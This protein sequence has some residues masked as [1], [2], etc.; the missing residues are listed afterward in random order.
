MNPQNNTEKLIKNLV[1]P[2][3][4]NADEH[5]LNDALAAYDKSETNKTS[6]SKTAVW[7]I[8]IQDRR[9]TI[10]AAVVILAVVLSMTFFNNT[11]QAWAIEDTIEALKKYKG[12]YL[13]GLCP[14]QKGSLV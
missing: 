12:A 7:R 8:I 14:G 2:G 9:T 6:E 5:I 4:E 1:L 10:A 11:N 3:T 13:A